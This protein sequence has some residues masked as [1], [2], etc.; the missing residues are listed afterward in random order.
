LRKLALAQRRG[1]DLQVLTLSTDLV[2]DLPSGESRSCAC[3]RR[4]SC[5][6]RRTRGARRS[7][8]CAT[9]AAT[10]QGIAETLQISERTVLRDWE[11]ARL[12]LIAALKT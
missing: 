3:M 8:R 2:A 9:S 1:G 7:S 4:S 11:K 10:A 5:S 6:S 12:P